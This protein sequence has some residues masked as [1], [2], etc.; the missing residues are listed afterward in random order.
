M[1]EKRLNPVLSEV[2]ERQV[3]R[4][5][6]LAEFDFESNVERAWTG[7]GELVW[8][9]KTFYGT[10]NLGKVSKIEETTEMKATGAS[11]Q[12]SAIPA[13]LIQD[14]VSDS[15]QGHSAK[16]WIGFMDA[17]FQNLIDEPHLIHDGRLDTSE[18]LDTG[19]TA[20]ITLNSETRFRDLD[21]PRTRRLTDAEQQKRFPGDKGLEFTPTMQDKEITLGA[22]KG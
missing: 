9:S 16:M 15:I 19:D 21:R 4:P 18:I 17:D 10:G 11:F 6:L 8:D 13:D 14:V 22:P 1:S 20:T 12:L 7:V 2:T 3:V 5:V